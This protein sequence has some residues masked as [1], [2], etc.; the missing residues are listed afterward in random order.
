MSPIQAAS[1][2]LAY[3]MAYYALLIQGQMQRGQT[4][5]VSSGY[6]SIGFAAIALAIGYGCKIFTIVETDADKEVING[7]VSRLAKVEVFLSD[8]KYIEGSILEA[9]DDHGIDIIVNTSL[10]GNFNVGLEVM[11]PCAKFL[12]TG[13]MP[14]L[15]D[16]TQG[17]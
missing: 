13:N 5:L 8:N 3:S 6:S 17:K 9:T 16:K 2:P 14:F 10:D 4:I 15:R 1:I 12:Q 11:A 7:K